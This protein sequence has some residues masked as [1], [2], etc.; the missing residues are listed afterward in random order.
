MNQRDVYKLIDKLIQELKTRGYSF[1]TG[2][3]Y[4]TVAKKYLESSK[5]PKE[6]LSS[7]SNENPATIRFNYFA[8]KFFIENVLEQKMD[9][10]PFIK[11]KIKIPVILS[12]NE[13]EKIIS[14]TN[15]KTH[16]A[17]LCSLYFAGLR[18]NEARL[19]KWKDID[20]ERDL[21][22]I[23]GR[24]GDERTIFLHPRLKEAL[25]NMKKS[26][27]YV[28]VSSFGKIY[29]ERTIQQIV[30]RAAQKA[31]IN[32]RVTP[33]TLRHSFAIHLLESGADTKQVQHLLGHKDSRAI[34]I[35]A[36]MANRSIKSLAKLL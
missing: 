8:L 32:K 25:L 10:I 5:S 7:L 26:S 23:R 1:K 14:S 2:K 24:R 3:N 22:I 6:F 13:V 19:L 36:T 4:I 9:N 18:L 17:V 20:F 29:D 33:S 15:N 35:Y 34:Q 27:E 12:R 31:K 21:L 11:N 28:F 16:F 30:T